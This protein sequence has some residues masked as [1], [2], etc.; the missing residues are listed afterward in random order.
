MT[1]VLPSEI[2]PR[3]RREPSTAHQERIIAANRFDL[4]NLPA[5]R[6]LQFARNRLA[7]SQIR[8][9][10]FQVHDGNAG[11]ATTIEGNKVINFGSYDYLGLSYHPHVIASAKA[12]IDRYGT[13][14]SASRLI[15][16]ERPIH[17]ELELRL[18]DLHQSQ[19]ALAF[20]SGHA[21]NVSVIGQLLSKQDLLIADVTIHNSI[22]EGGR[23]SGATVLQFPHNDYSALSRILAERSRYGRVLIVAEGVYSMDGDSIALQELIDIKNAHDCWLMIDEAHSAGVLGATGRGVAEEQGVDPA[24]VDIWMGTLSK[25]FAATGGYIA[26]AKNLIELLRQTT[27]G[28]V[29]SVG[30]APAQ[31]GAACAAIDVMKSEPDRLRRLRDNARLFFELANRSGLETGTAVGY[32]VIPVVIG[33]PLV[34]VELSNRLLKRGFNVPPVTFPAVRLE[35]SRLRFFITAE[36]RRTHLE[37]VVEATTEEYRGIR[38]QSEPASQE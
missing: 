24:Q 9:P 28:F 26:G 22:L 11:A 25:A 29:F 17:R 12:A 27:P 34:A 18:A 36:H 13:S 30:L 16:G 6:W 3:D 5:Y 15:A 10:F 21:T 8:Y 4:E 33:D 20:V 32:P 23:L 35:Q 31:A 7:S 37:Q 19:D 38:S 2:D 14:V 1:N